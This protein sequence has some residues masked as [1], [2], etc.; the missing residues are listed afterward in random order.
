MDDLFLFRGF[1]RILITLGGILC[2][3]HIV[4]FV[5]SGTGPGI[6]FMAMGC[7]VLIVA[8]FRPVIIKTD[9]HRI[10]VV[11]AP[12]PKD[13]NPHAAAA[14]SDTLIVEPPVSNADAQSNTQPVESSATHPS[15][16]QGR[17]VLEGFHE[18][19]SYAD[20]PN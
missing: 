10:D 4:S 19:R 15:Q 17:S 18:E 13:A 14:D 8:L 9:G 3:S 12:P 11:G 6:L 7:F 16:E 5:V 20:G 2:T 1:E